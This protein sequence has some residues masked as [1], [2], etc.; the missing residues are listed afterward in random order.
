MGD[1]GFRISQDDKDVKTGEDKE[2]V[3]TSKYANL[4]GSL[5]GSGSISVGPDSIGTVTVAHNFGYIP[6]ANVYSKIPIDNRYY[7]NPTYADGAIYSIA[8]RH[9][10][11]SSN[12]Y[13]KFEQIGGTGNITFNYKYFVFLDKAKL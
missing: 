4:K 13:L 3:L 7:V 1:W 9:Y 6:F 10:A 8:I 11:D 12:V 5:A 2:M